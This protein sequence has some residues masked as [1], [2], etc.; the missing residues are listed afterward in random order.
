MKSL[1]KQKEGNNVFV[2][3]NLFYT[4]SISSSFFM[5]TSYFLAQTLAI[6][7]ITV[8]IG[9]FVSREYYRKELPKLLDNPGFILLGWYMALI[10]GLLMLYVHNT[11]YM[12][13]TTLVT[14]VG[15]IAVIKGIWLIAFPQS[16]MQ[17]KKMVQPKNLTL[18]ASIVTALGLLFGYFG[19]L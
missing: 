9:L 14:L 16:M 5:E 15:W 19:F 2:W 12:D 7:Y 6:C 17:W 1:Q 13:W 18:I 8:G 11:W 3:E 4:H 10:I